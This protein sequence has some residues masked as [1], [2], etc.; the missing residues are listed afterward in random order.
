M[1]EYLRT[2]LRT[3]LWSA[4]AFAL[5]GTLAGAWLMVHRVP[6]IAEP[7][8]KPAALSSYAFWIPALAIPTAL[9]GVV[10]GILSGTLVFWVRR[11]ERHVSSQR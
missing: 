1:R 5:L 7:G 8:P 9:V 4:M 11:S 6:L 3:T 10:V 2:V